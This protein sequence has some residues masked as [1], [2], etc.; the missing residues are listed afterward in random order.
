MNYIGIIDNKYP[1]Y[2][3]T[4]NSVVMYPTMQKV[5]SKM[6]LMLEQAAKLEWA[7]PQLREDIYQLIT[8]INEVYDLVDIGTPKDLTSEIV[9]SIVDEI[10]PEQVKITKYIASEK[11]ARSNIY[12]ITVFFTI[13]VLTLIVFAPSLKNLFNIIIK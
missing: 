7:N 5:D 10:E 3:T 12:G 9:A 4:D 8:N 2:L 11:E 1:I 6:L 13:I